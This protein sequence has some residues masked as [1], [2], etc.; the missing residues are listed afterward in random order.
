M[1]NYISKMMPVLS[2][3]FKERKIYFVLN[4]MCCG[5]GFVRLNCGGEFLFFTLLSSLLS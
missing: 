2:L 1:G 3:Q 5:A 4:N